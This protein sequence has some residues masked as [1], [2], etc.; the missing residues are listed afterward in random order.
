MLVFCI[1][2]ANLVSVNKFYF[3]VLLTFCMIKA[4]FSNPHAHGGYAP[5]VDP[6]STTCRR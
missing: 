3:H 1:Q 5:H 2:I 4:L 6:R